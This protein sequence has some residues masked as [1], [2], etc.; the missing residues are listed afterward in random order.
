M[1]NRLI[2]GYLSSNT[3]HA[4]S[5]YAMR[6]PI[7]IMSTNSVKANIKAM[8]PTKHEIRIY[9]IL[10]YREQAGVT[11]S[12]YKVLQACY[13][14]LCQTD[15]PANSPERRVAI[16]GVLNLGLMVASHL[17]MRPSDAMA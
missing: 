2:G 13:E 16:N 3:L 7:D 4:T 10:I 14:I 6:V 11:Y 12:C 9:A 8:A 17:K 1:S 5:V 15:R